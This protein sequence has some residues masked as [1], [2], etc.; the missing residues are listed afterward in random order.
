MDTGTVAAITAIAVAIGGVIGG[1]VKVLIDSYRTIRK[2]G[3][4]EDRNTRIDT[5]KE[6]SD[7]LKRQSDELSS[8]KLEMRNNAIRHDKELA[9]LRR[10]NHECS[11]N[12][13]RSEERIGYLEDALTIANIPF[14][15][16]R[17]S[18]S[19]T[20]LPHTEMTE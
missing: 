19:G 12:Y 8:V 2:D 4:D 7:L 17:T 9:S 20:R 3:S 10:E 1:G 6:Y 13:A 5:L 16:R 15:K 14:S 18:D 11:Q